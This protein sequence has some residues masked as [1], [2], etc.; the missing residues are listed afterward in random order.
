MKST[1]IKSAVAMVFAA[2]FATA[3]MAAPVTAEGKGVGKHGDITVAVTFD[4]GKIQ[5][6]KIV[7]NAENPILAKKVFT[8]LKDQVVALSSTDVDLVSGATFSAK[9]FIDAVNDA[10]KKAGVTLA[11]ADK[12]ALK[13]AARELPKTSNYDVVVIGAGGAGFSAAITARNAGAN[14]VLLEK[15][16]AVGGNSLISGAEMNVAKNWVQPKLGINDDSPELHAQDTFKGGD[17]KGD[18]KV[19]N[20]M[21]HEALDAAK[22]CRDYLGVRFEDD[23]LF[24]FGGHS[25]KR[26]LIPVGHTG[27]EFI[28]KFQAKAD[29]L[30]IPV[31]TNMKAE[32]L[33]KDKDGRVVGVKAQ[34]IGGDEKGRKYVVNA[35]NG[36]I[37]ATGGFGANVEMRNAY[38]ELW[39]KK[40]GKTTPTTNLPSATGDGIT[41]AKQ[42]GANLV[43]MGWIQLFPAGDPQTGATSFKLGENSCIYVNRDGKRYV[44]ESE[45]RDVLAKANLAQKDGLF[46]VISSAKRALI[47]KDGRNAYGVKVEDI[48]ASGKSYKADT[49]EELAKKAGINAANLVETVKKWNEFCKKGTGD[50]MGRPTC[51]DEHRLDEGGPYYA[52]LMT[53]SVH[54]TM[55]GV[56][57][58]TKAQVINKAG[59]VI[60][61]LYAAGEVTGAIHGTNRV[62][63]NA[64]PDA[65]VFGHIAAETAAAAK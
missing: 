24:F 30:G 20:V 33:I 34:A 23:N 57:I 39:G 44:N 4:A 16:P 49:L 1:M 65:L 35:K 21:T 54:H 2:G 58:N 46:F 61:G 9:G 7:K 55:G 47:D 38:D 60:P 28:A 43:Q 59:K 17:G 41:M 40:L 14:V 51:M 19:I 11:K 25:R 63:C 15:M 27:T 52:T 22:W 45:R 6:I 3:S 53:P 31:I 18:M 29:E 26:A 5:D 36:V 13:K 37:L 64:V 8:D 48:L 12:K 62:G 50:E 42:V 56:Q 10:A 32:E